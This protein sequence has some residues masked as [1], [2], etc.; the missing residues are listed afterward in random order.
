MR[1]PWLIETGLHFCRDERLA[2]HNDGSDESHN[3]SK[4]KQGE[5]YRFAEVF[6]CNLSDKDNQL[7]VCR[8]KSQK[9]TPDK[10]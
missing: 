10:S 7:V 8:S 6:G 4:S 2:D 1:K 9:S 5:S 3:S